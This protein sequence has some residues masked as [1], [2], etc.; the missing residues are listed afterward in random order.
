MDARERRW[1]N[2]RGRSHHATGPVCFVRVTRDARTGACEN[3]RMSLSSNP[4]SLPSRG[5]VVASIGFGQMLAWGSSYYLLAIVARPMAEGL[6]LNPVWIY[7]AFSAALL[8]AALLGPWVGARI[9]RHGGGKVLLVSNA[10]FAMGLG[11]LALAHGPFSMILGWLLIGA[12]MPMGLYDAA[13]STL[14]SLYGLDARRS[15]VGVT[16]IAGFASSVSW[17][18]SATL[19]THFGWRVTCAVWAVLHLTVGAAIS[20]FLVPRVRPVPIHH[21]ESKAAEEASM[22]S[23]STLWILAATFT[24]NGFIFAAMAAHLPRLLQAA[25]CTPAAAVAA[26]A[27]LGVAQVTARLADAGFLR[28]LHPLVSG[29]IAVALHPVGASILLIFGAP[30][31]VVFTALHGANIGLMT[32]VKGTLPLALFGSAGFGRRAGMLEAPSR[33]AQ[34]LAPVAFGLMLDAWGARALWVSAAIGSAGFCGLLLLRTRSA[35]P[36]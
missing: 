24:C 30:A 22:P 8:L 20:R 31:A 5:R 10:V 14:V 28:R 23:A 21:A 9:D 29:R 3:R 12:A 13:F 1:L 18:L 6:G 7:S 25:G 33:I 16:L 19:D 35:R 4:E 32:I 15:I 11:T 2:R 27:F 17:P 34:A 36:I 26:A